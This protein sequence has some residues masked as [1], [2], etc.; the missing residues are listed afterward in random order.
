MEDV[1]DKVVISNAVVLAKFLSVV[2]A[3]W[4]SIECGFYWVQLIAMCY[5]VQ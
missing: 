1:C 3:F 5:R 2:V 4:G